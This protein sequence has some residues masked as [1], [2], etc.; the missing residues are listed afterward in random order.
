MMT[1]PARYGHT[2]NWMNTDF[3]NFN[4]IRELWTCRELPWHSLY[5]Q[6]RRCL[7]KPKRERLETSTAST[8]RNTCEGAGVYAYQ[9]FSLTGMLCI[10]SET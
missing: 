6:V 9:C 4:D 10:G 1:S 5:V 3:S 2:L 8:R 7:E